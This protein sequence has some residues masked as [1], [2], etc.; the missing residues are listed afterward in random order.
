MSSFSRIR[1]VA[2]AGL[3]IT[4]CAL[5]LGAQTGAPIYDVVVRNGQ[6]LDGAGNPAIRADV[7]IKGGRFARIGVVTG[8]GRQEIDAS[9]KYVSPGWIDMMDQSGAALL[10]N[11]LAEN[12]LREGVTTAIGGEGG[13]PVAAEKIPEYFATLERQG[14]SINFGTYFSETQARIAV[15]G[16]AN[17]AP[18]D[19]ELARMKAIME[20]AM[21]AGAMGM[22]T[23]L[24][25]P[26]SSYTTTPELIEVAKSAAKY[27]GIYASHIRGEGQEVVASVDEAITIG[28]KAGLP[29]EIF[30]LKVAHSP[31]WG[32]LMPEVG[33]HI[34]EARRRGVDVAADL[35]VYTAG[36]TG[37]EATIPSWA[38]EGGRDA[39]LKRL[40]DLAIRERLKQEIETGSPGWW[41]IIEAAGGWDGIVLVN[42][43][44]PANAR[45]EKK[46]MTAIAAEL[47]KDPAEAAFDLVSQGRGR[48]TAVYHM[49][50]EP[51]IETALRFP[52]TSIGSDAGAALGPDQP[53]AIGLP[54]PRAY[55][56]FPRVIAR[57]VRERHV[58]TLPEAIRKMT[59][60]PAT[61]MRLNDRGLIRDGLWADLVVF[62]FDKIQ[63]RS[64][65]EEPSLYPDGI[66]WVLV[67]GEVAI[68]RGRHTGARPGKVLY[69]PGRASLQNL[70]SPL[71]ATETTIPMRDGVKLY[72]QIYS[73]QQ[74]AE[75]LPIVLLRTPY[76][77]GSLNPDRVATSLAYLMSD[78]YIIVQQDIRGRFK[79]D[80]SF[81]MLRQPRDPKDT[82]G[83]ESID[84]STDTYDTIAWLLAN[85]PN[86]NGR[87]G[88][89]GTSYGAWLAVMGMLDPH[90]AL[91]AVVPQASPAD[92][93]IGDDFHH[94]GAFRLS[95]GLEYAYR[96]ESSKE[97]SD[98]AAIIDR[99]DTYDWYLELGPL[100][101]VNRKYFFEK[102]PTWN[103]FARHPDYDAFWKR[104]AFAPWLTR[105]TAP[106]LNVAGWWDQEDFYGPLK[107][108]ELLERHD[109]AHEN[110]LVVG[111]WNHGGW[112]S[113]E[114]RQLGRID[115]GSATAAYYR[116]KILA[117]FFAH[118][119][120]GKGP[121]PLSEALTFRTGTN[122]WTRHDTWPP[123]RN[124]VNRRLY[125]R[126]GGKLAFDP[127]AARANDQAYDSYVSDPAKPVPYRQ[128]PI[129]LRTGWPTW[130][131]EDQRFVHQRPDVLSWS[132]DPL[133]T[134]VTMTGKIVANLFASTTG[135]DSDWI[136][137][138]IDVYP[139]TYAADP[140]MGGY[141]LMIAGDVTRGRY[142][143]SIEKPE[144]LVPNAVQRY[145][146]AF[147]GNDHVF[148]AGHRIMVQVQST[149]FPVIDRNPQRFVSNIFQAQESD[150]QRAT[151]RV[152]RAADRAS[153]LAVPIEIAAR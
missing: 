39:L 57:Y 99:Y 65:Y 133:T 41:N 59:S 126:E 47:G 112:S 151:Q 2:S 67:N 116:E 117:P 141:Q 137:K 83:S 108:Y 35:Y 87:V 52:W 48:V 97:N 89:A 21:Q 78:G 29:V 3:A 73:P 43:N 61:R 90:P 11:G 50:T 79:S 104:Q 9:G 134:D 106:T 22:T 131:V 115:F 1:L 66:E 150:F 7:A 13:T 56:N 44:N 32:K 136:V 62:D 5:T 51:D 88:I 101:N 120:K 127:P 102:L 110:F 58:L 75:P 20:Q 4:I 86:N 12:K 24:I 69:G 80:G 70:S 19:E 148:R 111:P 113:G 139:E 140:E 149:W 128:R 119:L 114:G 33:R 63:D 125:L 36:G 14:I 27:G 143:K 142:R 16:N 103:D 100:S 85:V 68:D 10:V 132:T 121:P 71:A 18:T 135:T 122:A 40:A 37:L 93:W 76:G 81:V 96:M 123:T 38:H 77:I 153:Y 91:K 46:T 146:I 130:L 82:K 95:Y 129:R 55:G 144:A 23:A 84:E 98:P 147:A 49:M 64:T 15:I 152:F 54:H 109:S 31:G 138:V 26:P 30:H 60:W 107:I 8:R 34:E 6:V 53:D 42:A 94:N 25:Y 72:T 17:R 105:V 118:Y 145:E 124:V 92:M 28:E 45:F 74:T